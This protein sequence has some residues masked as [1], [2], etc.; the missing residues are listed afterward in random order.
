ML[1]VVTS[2]SS[3]FAPP[4]YP[5]GI[6]AFF[7]IGAVIAMHSGQKTTSLALM[8]RRYA[9]DAV[10][11]LNQAADRPR[12]REFRERFLPGEDLDS[13]EFRGGLRRSV[14]RDIVLGLHCESFHFFSLPAGWAGG[15]NSHRCKQDKTHFAICH[16]ERLCDRNVLQR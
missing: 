15:Y 11:Y 10:P 2:E 8:D 1:T 16:A 5:F 13:V 14:A 6:S 9:G 12:G 7:Y 3:L 4:L